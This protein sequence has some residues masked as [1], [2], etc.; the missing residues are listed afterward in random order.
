MTRTRPPQAFAHTGTHTHTHTS[1]WAPHSPWGEMSPPRPPPGAVPPA[2]LDLHLSSRPLH[3]D[4]AKSQGT[5]LSGS[6]VFEG[7]GRYVC[8]R[9]CIRACVF[10]RVCVCAQKGGVY[11]QTQVAQFFGKSPAHPRGKSRRRRWWGGGDRGLGGTKPYFKLAENRGLYAVM[12][13]PPPM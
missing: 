5:P 4:V 12:L 2:A 7:G 6:G 11:P 9:A 8:L 10:L 3:T 13:G 1:L